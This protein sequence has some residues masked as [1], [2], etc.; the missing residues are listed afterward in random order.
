MSSAA[1]KYE[2]SDANR[3]VLKSLPPFKDLP[4]SLIERLLPVVEIRQLPINH[5]V[6]RQEQVN[7][8][9]YILLNGEV[10]VYVDGG[11]VSQ[12]NETGCF[13][14]EMS[15]ITGL[16]CTA[17][18]LTESEAEVLC[19]DTTVFNR[20]P[21]AEAELVSSIFYRIYSQVLVQKLHQTNQKAKR[22][23]D[24]N[25]QL[26]AMQ[27]ELEEVNRQM[28]S[29]LLD[30]HHEA[31]KWPDKNVLFV[32][33]DKKQQMLAKMALGGLGIPMHAAA[34]DEEFI[35]KMQE[36][37]VDIVYLDAA[38]AALAPIIRQTHPAA[39]IVVT[40]NGDVKDH[41]AELHGLDEVPHL[42]TRREEDRVFTVKSLMT[43]TQ[44]ILSKDIFGLEKYLNWGV[45]VPSRA[46]V[47]SDQ[48]PELIKS[49]DDYVSQLG[50]R[51]ANRDRI[52]TV[53]EEMLMNAIFDAPVD[54]AGEPLFNH[55]DRT[56]QLE[57]T[58]EQ[59]GIFRYASDG[60]FVAI[61]VQD[62]FGSLMP[63]TILSYL[64]SC[65]KDRAGEMNGQK[66][67]KAGAGRGLHQIVEGADLV[68][69]NLAPGQK[70]EV[71]AMFYVEVKESKF[72]APAL[73]LFIANS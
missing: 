62:P 27:M 73:Q 10:G 38:M 19:I 5:M 59:Q 12:M 9:L 8:T 55:T 40:L 47:S 24:L 15:L 7:D 61:S 51:R 41:L 52:R 3:E 29:R 63:S 28:A 54:A 42:I 71:I 58:P 56:Q 23:E 21:P 22:F 6:L 34:T 43:S 26:E 39:E 14:G 68:I 70:T 25:A 20:M 2:S 13:L 50:V 53:A 33:T 69:F 18:I 36:N 32:E 16:P 11:K 45:E 44:K 65:Y 17:T 48:R 35:T 72:D 30:P 60:I 49:M 31:S 1:L 37:R 57:L 67:Q 66:A 64:E 46:I 4:E